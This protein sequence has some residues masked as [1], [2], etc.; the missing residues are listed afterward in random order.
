MFLRLLA[1]LEENEH[2]SVYTSIF[3]EDLLFPD[4]PGT[5]SPFPSVALLSLWVSLRYNSVLYSLLIEIVDTKQSM[6]AHT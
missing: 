2:L 6:V 1:F 5:L 3:L 4:L